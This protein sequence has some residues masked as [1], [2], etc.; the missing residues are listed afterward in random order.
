[1]SQVL[2]PSRPDEDGSSGAAV[3]VLPVAKVTSPQL[4]KMQISEFCA[5]L[6]TQTN[7]HKRPFQ[8]QRITDYAEPARALDR[9]MTEQEIDGDFTACDVAVLNTFF[10]QYR[11]DHGQGGTNT[12]QRNLHHIFKCSPVQS[13]GVA[14]VTVLD[15]RAVWDVT[16]GRP[17]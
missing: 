13:R 8:E 3:S 9:W 11:A 2:P 7:K 4:R 1:M 5:W 17:G 15:G 6:R 10:S 14:R 12:R 16:G